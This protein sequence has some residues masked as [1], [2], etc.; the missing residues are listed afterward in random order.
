MALLKLKS[1]HKARGV[2]AN[3]F[4]M[5]ADHEDEMASNSLHCVDC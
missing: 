2:L 5:S 4:M 1:R 3:S